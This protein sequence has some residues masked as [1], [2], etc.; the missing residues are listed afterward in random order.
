MAQIFSNLV[1]NGFKFNRSP[2]KRVEIGIAGER[3]GMCEL[4]VRDNGIGIDS[5]YHDRIFK[6]FK[7][8]H[9]HKEYEGTGIGLAIV[10]KAVA[11][12]YGFVRL[13]SEA[14]AGST[15][16]V[17]LPLAENGGDQ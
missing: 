4:L 8:L 17:T 12:I 9:T 13:E 6:M 2:V 16:F 11:K 3:D 7:R 15:F 14:G 10:K 1:V 5:R